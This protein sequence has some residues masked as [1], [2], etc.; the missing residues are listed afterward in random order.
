M[1]ISRTKAENVAYGLT[2]PLQEQAKRTT[3]EINAII[4]DFVDKNTPKELIEVY[5]KYPEWENTK[6][7]KKVY[8]IPLYLDV[9][10][11][12]H[13][14]DFRLDEVTADKVTKLLY[15]K[16]DINDNIRKT[17]DE[18]V[19]MLVSLK[20]YNRCKEVFPEAYALLP[21]A[22]VKHLPI[23]QIDQIREKLKIKD[24]PHVNQ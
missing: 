23:V 18:I 8:G 21:D 17:R 16:K 9:Q 12:W 11:S 22:E 19:N 15:V 1:N 10:I 24:I 5:K 6:T 14:G 2:K 3:N 20:T 7:Y 13:N 4:Q